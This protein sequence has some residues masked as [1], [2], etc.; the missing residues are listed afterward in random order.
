[1][2]RRS[3]LLLFGAALLLISYGGAFG[4]FV[5]LPF[6]MHTHG[7]SLE[8]MLPNAFALGRLMAS[9]LFLGLL[10]LASFAISR[11]LDSHPKSR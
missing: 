3:K 6:R 10:L 7:D 4:D 2:T 9:A 11:I 1:M 8:N 5:Y